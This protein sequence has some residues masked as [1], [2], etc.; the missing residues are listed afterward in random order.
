MWRLS[1]IQEHAG[2]P[3]KAGKPWRIRCGGLAAF[4]G[5]GISQASSPAFAF[6]SKRICLPSGENSSLGPLWRSRDA[7]GAGSYGLGAEPGGELIHTPN[8]PSSPWCS[9]ATAV[10]SRETEAE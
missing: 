3:P 6:R 10:P 7:N 2:V 9:Q 4:A 5:Y 1:G 8:I